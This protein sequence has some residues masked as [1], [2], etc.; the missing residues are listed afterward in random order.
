ME[1]LFKVSAV[2]TIFYFCYKLFLQRDT[3]FESNRWFLLAGLITAFL[4]PLYVI[5]EYIEYTP[6]ALPNYILNADIKQNIENTF[7]VLD[8]LPIIYLLGVIVFSARFLLQI[9]SLANLIFKNKK[10]KKS[11]YIFVETNADVS[12]FSFFNWIVYNPNQFNKEELSQIITHE[13][14]HAKQCHSIDVLLTQITC[15]LLWFNPFI[16]F[17][18]KDLKQ[19]LE[20]IADSS[21]I[22]YSE[23]KKAYQYTLLKTSLPTHQLALSNNFYNSLIKKRIVM[24]HKS[25]SKKINQIKLTLVLPLLAIFLMSFNTEKIY[26]AKENPLNK[27][28]NIETLEEIDNSTKVDNVIAESDK[29]KGDKSTSTSVIAKKQNIK[30]SP[31]LNDLIMVGINKKSTDSDLDNIISIFKEYDVAISFKDIKRNKNGEI[32]AIKIN[33]N[34]KSSNANFNVSSDS[35]IKLITIMFNKKDNSITIGNTA[36]KN[37]GVSYFLSD[38]DKIK[39]YEVHNYDKEHDTILISKDGEL[40]EINNDSTYITTSDKKI[41]KLKKSKIISDDDENELKVII[42]SDTV[43]KREDII[44]KKGK[45]KKN[46]K[47]KTISNDKDESKIFITTDDNKEPLFILDGKEIENKLDDINPNDIEKINILKG[48]R[49]IEKYGDKGKNGVVEIITKK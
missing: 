6:T 14:V 20:F 49:A 3:F 1:Y 32:T 25:K 35:A 46:Y 47:V 18:N 12:P 23:C 26:V 27:T 33:A 11:P 34:S 28:F 31:I 15:T 48:E 19:N 41:I 17:Y 5:T 13:K 39:V 21:A 22:N 30:K 40:H 37:N 42:E 4:I 44:I 7:N 24:L 45:T 9:K 43:N 36:T 29:K 16:W 10:Q 2:I 8:F 38:N